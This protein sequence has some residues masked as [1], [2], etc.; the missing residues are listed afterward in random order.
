MLQL[1][2]DL[3]KIN[4]L[5]HGVARIWWRQHERMQKDQAAGVLPPAR[6]PSSNGGA[7]PQLHLS[8]ELTGLDLKQYLT[9][10]DVLHQLMFS[11]VLL[12]WHMYSEGPAGPKKDV[13]YS[14]WKKLNAG[15]EMGGSNVPEHVQKQVYTLVKKAYIPELA[16]A[17]APGK[18]AD[19]AQG[20][21]DEGGGIG[22]DIAAERPAAPLLAPFAAAEGWAQIVG[23]GFPKPAGSAGVQMVTYTHVSSI[24]SEVPHGRP[25]LSSGL[26]RNLANGISE[27]RSHGQEAIAGGSLKRDDYAW[28]SIVHSLLFFSAQPQTGAPYAFI[29]LRK[30]LVANVDES[31]QVLT[32]FGGADP[33]DPDPEYAGGSTTAGTS[34]RTSERSRT[35]SSPV[36]IVILLPDGR[37]QE[38]SLPKLELRLPS[39]AG[40]AMWSNHIMAG[41]QGKLQKPTSQKHPQQVA[42]QVAEVKVT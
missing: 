36:T 40:L 15:I 25:S 31:G 42:P 8:E 19:S 33:D 7:A 41:S 2:D 30:V 20:G 17:S 10:S 14:T 11:T 3:Q 35:V 28:L 27:M 39:S 9:G 4:R 32:L 37:W 6:V 1:P 13:D 26:T 38:L 22:E 29:E 23:G 12:H 18:N 5:V 24:F 34:D 16:V 21:P